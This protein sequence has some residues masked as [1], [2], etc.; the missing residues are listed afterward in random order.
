[1]SETMA[2]VSLLYGLVRILR[3][4]A[5]FTLIG[6][7]IN[8]ITNFQTY[9]YEILVHSQRGVKSNLLGSRKHSH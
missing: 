4:G 1:M 8:L 9:Q 3:G 5:G 6:A 7:L 2:V